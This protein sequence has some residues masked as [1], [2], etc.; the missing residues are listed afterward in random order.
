M[1]P[2]HFIYTQ[3]STTDMSDLFK[4]ILGIIIV[5]FLAGF[6]FNIL[7]KIGVI[8]LLFLGILFLFNKVFG[9]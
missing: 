8:A 1:L 5:F 3:L 4:L 7:F 2:C 9:N 6:I